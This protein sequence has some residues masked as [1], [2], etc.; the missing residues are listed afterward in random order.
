MISTKILIGMAALTLAGVAACNESPADALELEAP[1]PKTPPPT[2][3]SK[4]AVFKIVEM[5]P[6]PWDE[7]DFT[8]WFK[9]KNVGDTTGSLAGWKIAGTDGTTWTLDQ[10]GT[11]EIGAIFKL[12]SPFTAKL[13]ND[14]G[15]VTVVSPTGETVQTVTWGRVDE[16]TVIKP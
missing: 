13:S 9:V 8:E 15:T 16:G 1:Q 10:G 5:M 2:S 7:D 3:S 14:G 6:N 12:T 11:L 4:K